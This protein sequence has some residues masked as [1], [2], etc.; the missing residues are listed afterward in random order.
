MKI[1]HS[2]FEVYSWQKSFKNVN[3]FQTFRG[4]SIQPGAKTSEMLQILGEN[5]T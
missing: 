4:F 3:L 2:S 5:P 1:G